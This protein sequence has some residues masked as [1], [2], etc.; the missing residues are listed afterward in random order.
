MKLK[1]YCK[2]IFVVLLMKITLMFSNAYALPIVND[3]GLINP[4]YTL[5][6][7]EAVFP[8]GTVIN[9]QY[10]SFGVTFSTVTLPSYTES[11]FRYDV[12]GLGGTF[13]GIGGHYI[14]SSSGNPVSI[15]FSINQTEAA[16]GLASNPRDISFTALLDGMPVETFTTSTTGG[17][18][19]TVNGSPAG[20]YGFSGII[21]NQIGILSILN[22]PTDNRV[23]IDNIQFNPIPEPSTM[24]LLITGLFGLIAYGYM[25]KKGEM[26]GKSIKL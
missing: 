14:G 12:Q 17:S 23:L 9:S 4:P 11:D 22:N 18:F 10:A 19:P 3:F 1:I 8:M 25:R 6:F 2:I 13:S 15:H 16:F 7:D 26:R 24:L 5:T 21:F 20:Y